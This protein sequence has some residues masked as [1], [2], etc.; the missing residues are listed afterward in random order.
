MNTKCHACGRVTLANVPPADLAMLTDAGWDFDD[1]SERYPSFTR[2]GMVLTF[3][4]QMTGKWSVR[5]D[6]DEE[7]AGSAPTISGAMADAIVNAEWRIA[8]FR[9]ESA[10]LAPVGET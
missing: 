6:S 4:E 10:R 9:E 7:E 5:F 8:R 3:Y 2:D 1:G